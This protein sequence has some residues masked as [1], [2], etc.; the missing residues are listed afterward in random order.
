MCHPPNTWMHSLRWNQLK[1]H[2]W[3]LWRFHLVGIIDHINGNLEDSRVELKVLNFWW[4]LFLL[5]TSPHPEAIQG[6]FCH[7]YQDIARVLG[8]LCQKPGTKTKYDVASQTDSGREPHK[9][10]GSLELTTYLLWF[11]FS[12]LELF[13]RNLLSHWILLT[14]GQEYD[15]LVRWWHGI[16]LYY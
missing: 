16:H 7:P 9:K 6:H 1:I 12:Y 14:Y 13:Q 5:M 2:W 8:A 3:V 11:F 4:V 10:Q 15:V